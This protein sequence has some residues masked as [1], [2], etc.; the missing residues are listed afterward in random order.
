MRR[1]GVSIVC[2]LVLVP[3]A[4]AA[5]PK[6]KPAPDCSKLMPAAALGALTGGTFTFSG[7]AGQSCRFNDWQYN[8]GGVM[9]LVAPNSVREW[10]AW[11]GSGGLTPVSIPGVQAATK[12]QSTIALKGT[13]FVQIWSPPYQDGSPALLSYDQELVVVKAILA[14]LPRQ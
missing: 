9:I 1:L 6:P 11:K 14:K 12:N 3:G 4:L 8:N 10:N 13:T 7:K 5:K 2:A